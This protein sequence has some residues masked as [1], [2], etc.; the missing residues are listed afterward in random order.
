MKN[1]VFG[2]VLVE[3]LYCRFRNSMLSKLLRESPAA[4]EHTPETAYSTEFGLE[5][6]DYSARGRA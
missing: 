1:V 4:I 5:K 6:I 2:V 3:S